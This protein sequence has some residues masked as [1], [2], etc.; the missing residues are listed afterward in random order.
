MTDRISG[1][2]IT[3]DHDIRVDDA[4]A[5]INAARMIK[6]V[7]SVDPIP[8]SPSDFIIHARVRSEFLTA[9][10]AFAEAFHAGKPVAKLL[11]RK[12]PGQ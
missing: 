9:I 11:G 3:L 8:A 7:L 4:E 2:I 12:E 1:L 5:L 6:G 10:H